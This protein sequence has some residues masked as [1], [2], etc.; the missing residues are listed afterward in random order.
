MLLVLKF[1]I[2]EGAAHS[3]LPDLHTHY[4][5]PHSFVPLTDDALKFIHSDSRCFNDDNVENVLAN[6]HDSSSRRSD[7]QNSTYSFHFIDLGG[8]IPSNPKDGKKNWYGNGP[9][10]KWQDLFNMFMITLKWDEKLNGYKSMV[11]DALKILK[12]KKGVSDFYDK[13]LWK[14]EDVESLWS[15]CAKENTEKACGMFYE[16]IDE[17]FGCEQFG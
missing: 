13:N 5:S 11:G 17:S 2:V 1:F 12:K 16:L 6:I 8:S 3:S 14:K 4:T 10:C 9:N 15:G 7:H